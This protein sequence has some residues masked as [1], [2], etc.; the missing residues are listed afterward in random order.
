[1]KQIK[2]IHN[3]STNL[4]LLGP[5]VNILALRLGEMVP[6]FLLASSSEYLFNLFNFKKRNDENMRRPY[7][8]TRG[9]GEGQ[10]RI[11]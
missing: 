9:K 6:G 2:R 7:K 10:K 5:Q 11:G 1:M 8:L 4:Y 3:E